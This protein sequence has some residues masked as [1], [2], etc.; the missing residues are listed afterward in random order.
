MTPGAPNGEVRMPNERRESQAGRALL[1]VDVQ[2]GFMSP[3]TRHVAGAAAVLQHRYDLVYVT[4]F[5]NQPG[6]PFRAWLGWERFSA[7]EAETALAFTP[8]PGAIVIEKGTYSCVDASFL[9]EL[10]RQGVQEVHLCGVDT[11][12]CVLQCAFNLFDAGVRPVVLADVCASSGG[13]ALHEYALA[14]LRRSLGTAQVCEAAA[15]GGNAADLASAPAPQR[16]PSGAGVPAQG[17]AS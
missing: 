11:D 13:S 4:R 17:A 12:A 5:V 9:T 2:R 14:I 7:S 10:Q 1:I 3:E 8:R 16:D 15:P 6:S